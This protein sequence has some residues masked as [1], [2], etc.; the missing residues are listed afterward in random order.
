MPYLQKCNSSV[1][2]I[3]KNH[4]LIIIGGGIHGLGIAHDLSSRSVKNVSVF[5][6]NHIASATS[7]WSTKLI[8]GGLRYLQYPNQFKLVKEALHERKLLLDLVPDIVK[9]LPIIYP[10]SKKHSKHWLMIK[11]GLWLYDRLAKDHNI[12]PHRYLNHDQLLNQSTNLN[13]QLFNRAYKFF[14]GQTDDVQ[15]CLRVASSANKFGCL[16]AEGIKVDKI[17]PD[18]NNNK[19][20]L[21]ITDHKHKS[22]SVTAKH[23][24]L[25]SGPWSK[26]LL[27]SSD[28]NSTI[29]G[30]NIK[31]THI[32]TNQFTPSHGVIL[33]SAKND[34]RIFFVLPWKDKTL[35]GTT[36]SNY[37]NA[38][39]E[40]KPHKS[41]IDYLIENYN[42]YHRAKLSESDIEYCFSGL[43]WL[44][45]K[46]QSLYKTSRESIFQ[47]QHFG[48]ATLMQLYGG[49][50]TSYRLLAKEIA[51]SYCKHI[52]H[53]KK[54]I[55]H[56]RSAWINI[57]N[58][59]NND[60]KFL[61]VDNSNFSDRF[62]DY[63]KFKTNY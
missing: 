17:I 48:K 63:T 2:K 9:P 44:A 12:A 50:L 59:A 30:I 41:E 51:D 45:K 6:K 20:N 3:A 15:L 39:D 32:I 38:A 19:F 37:Q 36:E 43:R 8:H 49:K 1:D 13:C 40:Q 4:D 58:N 46:N 5:E 52:K 47:I 14:D 62:L 56:K 27:Q 25:A 28:I 18:A 54:S 11:T 22:T 31:G 57:E 21:L 60:I 7:S 61:I 55:T 24:I 35:I 34:K 33:E 29:E 10:I 16:I 53:H 42:T 26:E 23:I